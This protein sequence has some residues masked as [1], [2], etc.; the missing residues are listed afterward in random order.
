MTD[1]GDFA[2][3]GP[4]PHMGQR[5]SVLGPSTRAEAAANEIR[6]RILDGRYP[7]GQPLKQDFL[8]GEL[9]VSRAPVREALVQLE[10]EGLIR[11]HPHRGAVVAELSADDIEELFQLRVMLEPML[12]RRSAPRLTAEDFDMLDQILAVYS[13][14]LSSNS[15]ARF[16]KLN[17]D[18]HRV[19]YRRADLPRTEAIVTT[20]LQAND[21]YARMQISYTA[22]Q[23]RADAE[24]RKI[25]SL[26]RNGD[27]KASCHLLADHIRHAGDALT[28][29]IRQRSPT[30]GA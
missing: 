18:L 19:L 7:G 3:L 29:F 23:E 13:G 27:V 25:V 28:A 5:G 9:G 17:S 2:H 30:T 14:E 16:G 12:L 26:C 10:A 22:G 15:V 4:S 8:A 11:I 6:N 21:R 24:H 20:L 1:L